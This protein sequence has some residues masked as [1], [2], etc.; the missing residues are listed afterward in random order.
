MIYAHEK[1]IKIKHFSWTTIVR[2]AV[3]MRRKLI[4][5]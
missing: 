5:A 2:I 4:F 1:N 3:F